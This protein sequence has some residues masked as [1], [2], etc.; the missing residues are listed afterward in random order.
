MITA[1]D[2]NTIARTMRR[3]LLPLAALCALLANGCSTSSPPAVALPSAPLGMPAEAAQSPIAP[4]TPRRVTQLPRTVIDYDRAL[5]TDA[6][7]QVVAKL[8]EASKQIDEIYL[9]Q[10]SEDTPS[11]RARLMKQAAAPAA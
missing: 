6:E 10:A 1:S 9:R 5:L 11:T 7:R 4:D 3:Y 2:D 8:I